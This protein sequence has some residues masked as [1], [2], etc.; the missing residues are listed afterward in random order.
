MLIQGPPGTGKTHTI[1]ATVA[2]ILSA[3]NA[4]TNNPR[5]VAN[6]GF[7]GGFGDENENDARQQEQLR[8]ASSSEKGAGVRTK[9]Q[10]G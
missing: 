2:T 9:Q 10:R 6:G 1:A 8:A 7:G 4:K 3:N 5:D